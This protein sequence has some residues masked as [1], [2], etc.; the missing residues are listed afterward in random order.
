MCFDIKISYTLN[1]SLFEASESNVQAKNLASKMPSSKQTEPS[2]N[3]ET[4][5]N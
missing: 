4:R 1:W 2:N 3:Y 5:T